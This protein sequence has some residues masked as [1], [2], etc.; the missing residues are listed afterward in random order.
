MNNTTT[1]KRNLTIAAIFIVAILVVGVGTLAVTSAQSAFAFKKGTRDNG[2]SQNG[3]TVTIQKCKQAAIQSGWDNDQ[4]QE[5]E[6][7]ICTHPGENAT[8]VQ[9]GVVTPTPTTTTTTRVTGQGEGTSTCPLGTPLDA[10]IAFNV[11]QQPGSAVQGNFEITVSTGLVKSGTL[12]S[13]QITGNSFTIRGTE[14]TQTGPVCTFS[15]LPA[16]AT[17][18]G[19]CGTGVT[20]DFATAD[21]E[22]ARFTN[23][24]V[25]CTTT[26]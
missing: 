20:I 13:V 9:E 3:N 23:A 12:D 24:N 25:Q 8:C 26:F 15:Q 7:L 17:I 6:N 16:S 22:T 14:D 4:E 21:G 10:S 5:C 19:Q 2:N 18:T 1:T 11:V